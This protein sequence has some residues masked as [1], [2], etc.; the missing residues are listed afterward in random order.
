MTGT[1]RTGTPA[2]GP[3]PEQ[4]PPP[5]LRLAG[6]AVF[7]PTDEAGIIL[8]TRQDVYLTLNATATVMLSAALRLGSVQEVVDHLGELIDAPPAALRA[9]IGAL[10]GQLDRHGLLAPPAREGS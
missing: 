2:P 9:G 7:D 1:P 5:L 8:D 3:G 6:H 4:A 10:T